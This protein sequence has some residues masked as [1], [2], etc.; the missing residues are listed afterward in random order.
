MVFINFSCVLVSG[1]DSA[2]PL[3]SVTSHWS[4]ATQICVTFQRQQLWPQPLLPHLQL[5]IIFTVTPP[6][7]SLSL[8]IHYIHGSYRF[9]PFLS[10]CLSVSQYPSFTYTMLKV[11]IVSVCLSFKDIPLKY[12][13]NVSKYWKKL[14]Q[15]SNGAR[16]P[17]P[18]ASAIFKV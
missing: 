16:I 7:L 13:S 10:F 18:H 11:L 14:E 17:H 12:I 5:Y 6:S 15:V 1:L 2:P 8:S 3:A 9:F 4:A